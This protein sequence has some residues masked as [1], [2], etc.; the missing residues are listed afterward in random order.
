MPYVCVGIL[1]GF[2]V[3]FEHM[4]RRLADMLAHSPLPALPLI[5]DHVDKDR[6]IT[7]E[8]EKW[9]ILALRHPACACRIQFVF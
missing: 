7:A 3:S 2:F 6:I 5:V 8:E 4:A 1:P 9:M